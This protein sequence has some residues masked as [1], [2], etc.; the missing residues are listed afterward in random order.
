MVL[1]EQG[2][3]RNH[4]STK[5][6]K[7]GQMNYAPLPA[8]LEDLIHRVIGAAIEVHRV[9]GPGHL[10]AHYGNAFAIELALREI[11]FAREACVQLNYKGH[12]VGQG[13]LDFLIE[14]RLVVELKAV[15]AINDIHL[16]QTISYLRIIDQRAGLIL[17]F[18]VPAMNSKEAIRRVIVG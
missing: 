3:I 12:I 6:Q 14:G 2:L 1:E 15:Q 13:K 9:L 11:A 16:A 8:D 18:H 10:E 4:K 5:T 17:N 7:G